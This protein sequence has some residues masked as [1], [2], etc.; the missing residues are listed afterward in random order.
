MAFPSK[1]LKYD[2]SV[3]I[4]IDRIKHTVDFHSLVFLMQ[5]KSALVLTSGSEP[6]VELKLDRREVPR[7][8]QDA[9]RMLEEEWENFT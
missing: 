9:I 2:G 4:K 8:L 6:S 5:K 7:D 1:D 3:K